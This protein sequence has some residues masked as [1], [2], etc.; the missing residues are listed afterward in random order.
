MFRI[1]TFS[2]SALLFAGTASA[3]ISKNGQ[4]RLNLHEVK[5]L[6]TGGGT[7][8]PGSSNY[9]A[10]KEIV[11]M[12]NPSKQGMYMIL[13]EIEPNTKI[14]AHMHP[15]QRTATVLSGTWHFGYGDKFDS[16]KLKELPAGSI[17]S[18]VAGQNHFAMTGKEPVIVEITGFGPSGV[19]YVDPK[20]DPSH[21]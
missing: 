20:D 11:I 6:K 21:K 13:L 7:N 15:D 10:V 4:F 16:S 1:L 5:T 18:E 14:A 12:G 17:Y 9:S 8:A 19:T 3:Q 2:L